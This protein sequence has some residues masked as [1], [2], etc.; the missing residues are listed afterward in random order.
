M[1]KIES[2]EQFCFQQLF[3]S[4]STTT[5]KRLISLSHAF[6]HV[7]ETRFNQCS[8]QFAKREFIYDNEIVYNF[9]LPF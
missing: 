9:G 8:K 4:G 3:V 6:N 2:K 5:L 7:P 1:N